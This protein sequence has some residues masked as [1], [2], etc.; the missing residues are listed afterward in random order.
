M[1]NWRNT[2]EK[3]LQGIKFFNSNFY[4]IREEFYYLFFPFFFFKYPRIFLFIRVAI[5]VRR[6]G[7]IF[8]SAELS[9]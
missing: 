8:N 5:S 6:V 7:K 9:S 1:Y 4:K 2:N 3:I